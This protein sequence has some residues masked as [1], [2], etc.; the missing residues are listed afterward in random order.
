MCAHVECAARVR[1]SPGPA[2]G[3]CRAIAPSP[4]RRHSSG[5]RKSGVEGEDEPMEFG[6]FNLMGSREADKPAAQVFGEGVSLLPP[7][8]NGTSP[9]MPSVSGPWGREARP[10]R[11]AALRCNAGFR[12]VA[13]LAYA[14]RRCR[15]RCGPDPGSRTA[16][17]RHRSDRDQSAAGAERRRCRGDSQTRALRPANAV[18]SGPSPGMLC[19]IGVRFRREFLQGDRSHDPATPSHA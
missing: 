13:G 5:Q 11:R 12:E 18:L 2:R 19:K 14:A 9:S 16:V 15:H 6:I 4:V 10:P 3:S 1:Q 7:R 8:S 17:R